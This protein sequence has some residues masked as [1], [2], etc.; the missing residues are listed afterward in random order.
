MS[1]PVRHHYIPIFYLKRWTGT[2]G[3]LCEYSQP[4]AQTK[5]LRKAPR[6]T[7]FVRGLYTVPG[8][9]PEAAQ[10]VE[11]KFMKLTDDWAS[12]AVEVLQARHSAEKMERYAQARRM[13]AISVFPHGPQSR[14]SRSIRAD[15]RRTNRGGSE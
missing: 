3:K 13:G 8:V 12:Q 2:D 7:A 9:P 14:S 6:S 15:G 1:E 10:F 11:K 4:H 5:V